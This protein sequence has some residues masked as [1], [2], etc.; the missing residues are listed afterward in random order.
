M[1]EEKKAELEA[2]KME[3]ERALE[4]LEDSEEITAN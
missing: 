3:L 2:V 1:S 4:K